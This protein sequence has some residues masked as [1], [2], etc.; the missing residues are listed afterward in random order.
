MKK[1]R[2]LELSRTKKKGMPGGSELLK[3]TLSQVAAMVA[4][5]VAIGPRIILRSAIQLLRANIWTRLV[6]A[7]VLI[8]FDIYGY[9]KKKIS[10]KQLV[11]NL[12]LAGS[13]IFGGT[14]GWVFGTD[15]ALHIAAE[16]T[17]IWVVAGLI[18]AGAAGSLVEGVSRKVLG[19]FLKTDVEDMLDIINDEFELM[20]LEF[21]L[22]EQQIGEI[23]DAI[24]IDIKV[25][26]QCFASADK[27][28]YA[29][30]L[31]RPYFENLLQERV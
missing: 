25:C 16:N 27:H 19:R 18:G 31:M 4:N 10:F 15:S 23:A 17:V 24:A 2:R 11:I 5:L 6:S 21:G 20:V 13:L 29:R 1:A 30:E 7:L 12:I 3:L 9:I 14:V 26:E 22:N 28:N 8:V